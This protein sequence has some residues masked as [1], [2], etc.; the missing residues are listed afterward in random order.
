MFIAAETRETSGAVKRSGIQLESQCLDRPAPLNCAVSPAIEYYKHRTPDGA[1]ILAL[2]SALISIK[3]EIQ[4]PNP[5]I[6]HDSSFGC[7][8]C[9]F[10]AR[11]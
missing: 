2:H 10:V 11:S 5:E 3:S 1:E 8:V 4:N 7:I 9:Q 6:A